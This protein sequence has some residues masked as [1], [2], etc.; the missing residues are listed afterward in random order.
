MRPL[1][2]PRLLTSF[3][4]LLT[5]TACVLCRYLRRKPALWERVS[6]LQFCHFSSRSLPQIKAGFSVP[7]GVLYF[8]EPRFW[9]INLDNKLG[10]SYREKEALDV[11]LTLKW[12]PFFRILSYFFSPYWVHKF[13]VSLLFNFINFF[14]YIFQL[15]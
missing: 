13:I 7:E 9:T 1:C 12:S 2:F 8:P 4:G 3:F 6:S 5:V 11:R 14:L 15:F 10:N